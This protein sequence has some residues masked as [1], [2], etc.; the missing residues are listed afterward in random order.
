MDKISVSEFKATCLA[1]IE[2]VRQSGQ[3][4]VITKHGRPVAEVI[5]VRAGEHRGRG[6][7][8][9]MQGEF[10]V[11][12]DIVSPVMSEEEWTHSLLEGQARKKRPRR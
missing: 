10:A 2:R 8:G 5:P 6:F 12:G 9:R 1:V 3:T 7:L 11:V 4:V